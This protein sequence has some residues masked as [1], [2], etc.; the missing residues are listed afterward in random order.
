[1]SATASPRPRRGARIEGRLTGGAIG[2][3]V[4]GFCAASVAMLYDIRQDTWDRAVTDQSN[5][6]RTL[7]QDIGRTL[8]TYD[9]S[10]QA[11]AD[12]L[13]APGLASL[14]GQ[15]QDMVLY[16]RAASGRDLG[17][18][19]VVDAAGRVVRSSA[20]GRV[21]LDL[22]SRDVFLAQRDSPDRGLYV[23]APFRPEPSGEE[24][25]GLS[26]RL[27]GPDGSFA[28][29][30]VGTVRLSYFRDLFSRADVGPHGAITL[31]RRDGIC[32]MRVPFSPSIVGRSFA[33]SP[34]LR[35]YLDGGVRLLTGTASNDGVRRIYD[36][37]PVGD[38]PLVLNVAL[39]EADVFAPWRAK[40]VALGVALATLCAAAGLLWLALSRQ[41]RRTAA[42]ERESSASEAQYRL[43]ADHALD[44]IIRL[45]RSLRRSYVSPAVRA[46][47]GYAPE[48]LVGAT[49]RALVHPDDWG[50][51]LCLIAAAQET[52]GHAD[53]TYRLRHRDGHYIWME[54]RYNS[55]P[56]D[57]GFI[58]VLRDVTERRA[59]EER[60]AAA[61]AELA[62][63]ASSDALTGLANRRRF[64][65][66]LAEEVARARREGAPLSLLMLD[67]DRF[68]LYNDAYGHPEGDACLR[69]VAEALTTV[70]RRPSDLV[71]RYGGEEIA[72]LL[73]ATDAEGALRVAERCRAAVA[74]LRRPH[75]GNAGCG[76]V[77]TVSIG[78]AA[79]APER[80]DGAA[81]LAAADARL[82][83]AKRTGRNRAVGRD[84]TL[85]LPP[86]PAEEGRRLAVMADYAA[87]GAT[88]RSARLDAIAEIAARLL[89]APIG[90]V[91]LVGG[92]EVAF[93]GCHGLEPQSLPREDAYCS[94]TIQGDEPLV[95]PD[96][97][98]D[99][100][101]A[102]TA[103][104]RD[105]LGFYAGA[106]L[107][108]PLEGRKLGS[109]CVLDTRSRA[110][111]DAGQRALLVELAR[112]AVEDLDRRRLGR[113]AGADRLAPRA[114]PAA[115]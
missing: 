109:L 16:D 61:N 91:T 76:G 5:L 103:L 35:A 79:L 81:L 25:V 34:N 21:G 29:V 77:V 73:P 17:A 46:V 54:G 20:P 40:A 27:T 38:L 23:G 51:V 89:G 49:P 105:G 88:A 47:L 19:L 3:V 30:V 80:A 78:C 72:V 84:G 22:A 55:V 63:V 57:G 44:V 7:S 62:M 26:R 11:A 92:E 9:L 14:S 96:T 6:V 58:V 37:G 45:D 68:K 106:P 52:G 43:L 86:A 97:R 18:I 41:I 39:A 10:L 107:V 13:A 90:F 111:L 93:A 70:V 33:A 83:E 42:A 98:A 74:E 82:Y 31:L 104:T 95:V 36:F 24:V 112:L 66:A 48:D 69:A 28:G 102:E 4:A 99:P 108:S 114:G 75:Q 12:G 8:E 32:I 56:D 50:A 71:A 113:D 110:P 87:S 85:D 60:L 2:L 101:F 1:M 100:R 94:Y 15:L 115:A 65:A 67:V 64:D 59:A 53:A